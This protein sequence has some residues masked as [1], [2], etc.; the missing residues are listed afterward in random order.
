[1]RPDRC[2]REVT[3]PIGDHA[4]RF[5][6]SVPLGDMVLVSDYGKG[7]CTKRLLA[8]MVGR[9]RDARVPILVDPARSRD[10]SDYGGVTLIKANWAEATEARGDHDARPLVLAR[11]LADAHR[12]SVVVT[13]GG[14]GMVVAEQEG[15]ACYLPAEATVV[16]D[17]CGA[18]DTVLAAIGSAMLDGNCLR[19]ACRLATMAGG[20]QVATL[21][22]S[23][24]TPQCAWDDLGPVGEN[25][26]PTG[27]WVTSSW[28]RDNKAPRPA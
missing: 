17:V 22:V 23:A 5:L 12:C 18:G 26:P 7:V 3:T 21:G 14:H 19:G 9:A 2:D 1:L 25:H 27:K 8:K 28:L 10:W 16:R 24:V 13:Y 4:E 11:R 20:R 6:S 15:R